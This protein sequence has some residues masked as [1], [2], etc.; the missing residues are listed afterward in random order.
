M[1][2]LKTFALAR[3]Y[4]RPPGLVVLNVLD[5]FLDQKEVSLQRVSCQSILGRVFLESSLSSIENSVLSLFMFLKLGAKY[6]TF[7]IPYYESCYD[8][9][10]AQFARLGRRPCGFPCGRLEHVEFHVAR[11]ATFWQVE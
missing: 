4:P 1:F 5:V 3:L 2:V 7:N 8:Y 6:L 10:F 11:P 9:D